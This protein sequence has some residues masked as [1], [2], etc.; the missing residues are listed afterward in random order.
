MSIRVLLNFSIPIHLFAFSHP[1]FSHFKN[2]WGSLIIN[3][4]AFTTAQVWLSVNPGGWSRTESQ[5]STLHV[6]QSHK[7]VMHEQ[8]LYEWMIFC[9]RVIQLFIHSAKAVSFQDFLFPVSPA[10]WYW[11]EFDLSAGTWH[12]LMVIIKAKADF[13]REA[14]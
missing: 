4:N 12:W 9:Q 2:S 14:F 1:L 8:N 11:E 7:T 13:R 6:M 5:P 10:Q 3:G